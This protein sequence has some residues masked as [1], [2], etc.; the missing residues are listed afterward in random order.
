MK[1]PSCALLGATGLVGQKIIEIY[2]QGN[3]NFEITELVASERNRNNAYSDAVNWKLK[4][5]LPEKLKKLKLKT[6]DEVTSDFAISALPTPIAQLAEPT[7][8]SK[9]VSISSNSSVHR[10][11][12]YVPL[13]IPHINPGHIEITKKQET[14]GKIVTNPN[15][16]STI[17][18]AGLAPLMDLS[19]KKIHIVTLQSLSGAGYPGVSSIDL[20]DNTIPY[21]SNEED[22]IE[23]ELNKILGTPLD[24]LN[25][26][27]MAHAH[28]VPT[29]FGHS[30]TTHLESS[31]DIDIQEVE[32]I[33]KE[34]TRKNPEFYSYSANSLFPQ[35]KY[36]LND[37]DT[38]VHIGRLKQAELKNQLGM[39][40][41][42]HNLVLG[43]AWSALK[44]LEV[45]IQ[46]QEKN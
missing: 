28:R 6:W 29:T 41:M 22:K 17:L 30:I 20:V 25:I 15:C 14:M 39:V 8:L 26:P 2:E 37:N 13:M 36:H 4:S 10:M 21:I 32:S 33:Y 1:K 38:R 27:I 24:Q 7:L 23:T 31:K 11:A 5:S 3:F 12:K 16:A 34:K 9:G 35:V 45:L 19:I 40:F 42:G 46:F 44:N 18:A 43:A